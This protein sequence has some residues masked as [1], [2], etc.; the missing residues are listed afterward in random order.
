MC[1]RR[2]SSAPGTRLH[3]PLHEESSEGE[4]SEDANDGKGA[5]CA[6]GSESTPVAARTISKLKT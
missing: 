1:T 6:R 4:E 2:S 3:L 5:Q